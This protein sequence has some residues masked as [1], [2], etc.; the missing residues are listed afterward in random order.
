MM[1][2]YECACEHGENCT[3]TT[4]CATQSAVE[5]TE[6]KLE[7]LL[8]YIHHHNACDVRWKEGK[9]TCGLQ[10]ILDPQENTSE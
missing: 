7:G 2:D 9:C 3:R 4:M 8:D 6:A 1:N 5:V 10:A